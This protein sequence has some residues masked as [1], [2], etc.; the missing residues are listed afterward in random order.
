MTISAA[1]RWIGMDESLRGQRPA[2]LLRRDFL[3]KGKIKTAVLS[4]C[5]LG[6]YEA[7]INGKRVGDHLLDPTQTDYDIRCFY[8][9]YDVAALLN[10]RDN[11]LGVILGD[12]WFHQS[13]V[14]SAYMVYGEPRLIATLTVTYSDGTPDVIVTDESWRCAK[15]PI[16]SNNFYAGEI[17]DARLERPGWNLAGFDDS[18]LPRYLQWHPCVIMSEPGGR[19]EEQSIPPMRVIDELVPQTIREINQGC[20]VADFGR[21]FAGW[22]RIK[23]QA[24]AG[25]KINLRFGETVSPSGTVDTQSC[26][27]AHTMTEQID[28]YICRGGGEEIWEPRFTYHGFRYVEITGWPGIPAKNEL[29]GVMLHTDLRM[30]GDFYCS[31]ARLNELHQMA[32]LTH[33]SN[34][35]GIPEDCPVRERCG[36]LGDA[37]IISDFSM[38]NFDG[39]AFWQKYLDDIESTRQRFDG[40]PQ[41][42]APGRR[43]GGRASVDWMVA[44]IIIVHT[45]FLHYGQPEVISKHWD[46][47]QKVIYYL[48]DRSQN[49]LLDEGL[50]D[51]FDPGKHAQPDYTAPAKT[52]TLL[53]GQAAA[54]MSYLAG[55]LGK[56]DEGK[57]Y[58]IWAGEIR[59]AFF[60]TYFDK[61]NNS[62]GSQ[63]ADAMAL[64]LDFVPPPLT[65]AVAA[66][67]DRDVRRRD[68]HFTV[69][70]MGMKYLFEALTRH[71]YGATALAL[72][73]Q[74]TYP[75]FGE[76]IRR[77]ATTLWE[78]WGEAE[79]DA[80]HGGRSLN[81]PMM[82]GYNGWF[83]RM[84]SGIRPD[85]ENPGFQQFYAAPHPIQGLNKLHCSY[86]SKQG[87][88]VSDWTNSDNVF[89]WRLVV[90]AKSAARVKLPGQTNIITATAGEHFFT[91]PAQA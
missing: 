81:H 88:I 35:H 47:L 31:D 68:M 65:A 87:E 54:M 49:W 38:Y 24:P 26:G 23:V 27:V 14:W 77:G 21:N 84:L 51:W 44:P 42:I 91:Q 25:T 7:W 10:E 89:S 66:A 8:V 19:L 83:Y 90:P 74:D 12:G 63:T 58:Q 11:A 60:Q 50:G 55:R 80:A 6:C 86:R 72:M 64:E 4:I 28:S 40:L 16:L 85:P 45:H 48:K 70:I 2:P 9:N 13:Q 32:V 1:A 53:F 69:G 15:S 52:S 75:S 62:F 43:S 22:V 17:Y 37:H 41:F 5:G 59:S 78:Y 67:I 18:H 61:A 73:H 30:V 3:L 29:T 36:W 57:Q 71:G 20:H 46:C 76:L 34:L 82:G 56:H 79:V 39:E 33:R